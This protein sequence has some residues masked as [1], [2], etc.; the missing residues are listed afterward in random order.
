[1][2]V[3]ANR[4]SRIAAIC[5]SVKAPH[6]TQFTEHLHV[7]FAMRC[8]L[9]DRHVRLTAFS[10]EPPPASGSSKISQAMSIIKCPE[11]RTWNI[12]PRVVFHLEL[13]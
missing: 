13:M 10:A 1:V 3:P 6:E 9:A 5:S 11:R 4:G 2:T 7:L 12:L 8:G